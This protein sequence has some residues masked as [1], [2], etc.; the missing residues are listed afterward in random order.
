MIK[1]AFDVT[2]SILGLIILLPF[3]CIISILIKID[4][5]GPILFIQSRVGKDFHDFNIYK[6]R[7]MKQNSQK[8]GLLTLGL[9]DKR[10]TSL[11]YLLRKYKIDEL[12]QLINVLKGDMS[13]VGPRPEI[14][15]FINFYSEDDLSVLQVRPGITSLA[16]LNYIQEAEL[17]KTVENPEIFFV[18]SIIP[19]KLKQDKAYIAKQN[20]LLD[21]KIIGL[22]VIKILKN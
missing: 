8:K 19:N 9:Q 4:S 1:R 22:T 21:L 3:L 5:K 20:F 6:F 13:F 7:T 16:S 18:E 15:Y 11:G 12:P 2:F 17:L 14:R 10:I